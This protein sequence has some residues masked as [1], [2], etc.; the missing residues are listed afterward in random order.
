MAGFDMKTSVRKQANALDNAQEY[1]VAAV[2][3][4]GPRYWLYG[5]AELSVGAERD[6]QGYHGRWFGVAQPPKSA[7]S[8]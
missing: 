4:N 2:F 8:V 1:G 7:G 6:F 3:K 5:W